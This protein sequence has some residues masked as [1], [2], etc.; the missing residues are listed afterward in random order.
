MPTWAL[1]AL[2][3]A[4][5]VVLCIGGAWKYEHD[6]AAATQVGHD[7]GIK[8]Q[9]TVETQNTLK[10]RTA[11]EAAKHQA[12]VESQARIDAANADRDR[13]KSAASSLQ[14]QLNRVRKIGQQYTGPQ[15]T[16][17][18]TSTII[19]MLAD[20]LQSSNDSY[21][22]TAAEAD[23]YYNAGLTCQQQYESLIKRNTDDT[24]RNGAVL[25]K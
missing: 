11:N 9:Q 24:Q 19:N 25:Q 18:S 13:A 6:V 23:S 8:D 4:I 7:A 21:Q 1:K 2:P 20:M 5:I 17:T 15:P 10:E 3:Y 12:E 14:Q 16:G 22:L